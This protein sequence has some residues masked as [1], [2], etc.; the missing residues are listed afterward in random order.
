MSASALRQSSL[1][2]H[3]SVRVP[4]E[5][6]EAGVS[7]DPSKTAAAPIDRTKLAE[8]S[9]GDEAFEHEMLTER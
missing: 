6:T 9:L 1:A 7:W 3:V 5:E 8:V 4:T 2:E